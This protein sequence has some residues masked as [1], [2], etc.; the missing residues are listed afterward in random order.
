MPGIDTLAVEV[1]HISANGIWIL[2]ADEEFALPYAEFP[3][4]RNAI[5][6]QILIV[7]RPT[8]GHLYWPKL[9][10][11]LAVASIKNPDAFPQV[12]Q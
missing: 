2:I 12:V 5:V 6:D 9:D 8:A 7:E 4:F 11:D 1:T 10:I 3:R